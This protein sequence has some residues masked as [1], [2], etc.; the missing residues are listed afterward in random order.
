MKVTVKLSDQ[1]REIVEKLQQAFAEQHQVALSN[2]DVL[3]QGLIF[4]WN[5]AG[6][7]AKK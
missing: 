5:S 7:D 1:E 3:R 6:G 2:S 4:M